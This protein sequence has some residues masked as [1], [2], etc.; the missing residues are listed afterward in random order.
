MSSRLVPHEGG[1]G[2]LFYFLPLGDG[3]SA[4]D[5]RTVPIYLTQVF[6]LKRADL[7]R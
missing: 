5:R 4:I 3:V 1:G 7:W 6:T 2:A